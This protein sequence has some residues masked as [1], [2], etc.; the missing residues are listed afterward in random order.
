MKRLPAIFVA[1]LLILVACNTSTQTTWEEY[2]D[3]REANNAWLDEL[4]AK[5]NED[6]SPYYELVVPDW[7]PGAFVL[8]HYFNDRKETEGHLSPIYTSTIDVRYH[9]SL[10]DGT[11]VDSSSTMTNYGPGVYRCRL[12]SMIQG[13]G[14]AL[15]HM[16]CGDTAEIICPYGVAYGAASQGAVKPYS[17][18]RFGV[19]LV[20]VA[21]LESSP[22]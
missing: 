9:L 2:T 15:P 16:R 22:Y 20:D 10:Y 8:I 17:N 7:N 11:P 19:R 5:T 4:K 6:G 13:W 14:I 18:L 21:H 3:W 12:N 1:V